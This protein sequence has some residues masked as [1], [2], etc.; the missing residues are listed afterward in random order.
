[1]KNRFIFDLDDTLIHT[2]KHYN[3][4]LD[5]FAQ[6]VQKDIGVE[7]P[8]TSEILEIQAKVDLASI[9]YKDFAKERFP[10]SLAKTYQII[11]N[12]TKKSQ[13]ETIEGERKAYE[14]GLKVFDPNYWTRKLVAGAE[15]TLNFLTSQQE[16]LFLLTMGDEEVQRKKIN[17]FNLERWF[18]SKI[19]IV[20]KE[21]KPILENISRNSDKSKIWM[22]GN[23]MRSDI[24]PALECGIWGVYIPQETWAYDNHPDENKNHPRK[25]TLPKID[26]LIDVYM[27]YSQLVAN[28]AK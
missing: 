26:K 28:R 10:T 3:K 8:S 27:S 5:R 4:V 13:I 17:H 12:R 9:A 2:A 25:I 1:M 18:G 20:P 19:H 11:A 22:V 16:E 21:K 23:S 15:D 14:I 6:F 7:A 24:I